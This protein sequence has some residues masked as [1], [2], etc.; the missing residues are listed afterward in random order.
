MKKK[1]YALEITAV[2][3]FLLSTP[4]VI[5]EIVPD[6]SLPN[7]STVDVNGSAIFIRGGT[8]RGSN[9][10][11]SFE[12]FSIPIGGTAVFDNAR[13]IVNIF[14]RISGNTPSVIEGILR[15][16]GTAN[17]FLINPSGIVFG[18]GATV[19]IGGSLF[20]TTAAFL[21]FE[22][23]FRYESGPGAAYTPSLTVN[24]PI[25]L[26]FNAT[27]RAIEVR[28]PGHD[29]SVSDP[30]FSPILPIPKSPARIRVESGR[31]LAL[32]GGKVTLDGAVLS[33]GTVNIGGIRNG[34]VLFSA[35]NHGF[36]FDYSQ[37]LEFGAINLSNRSAIWLGGRFAPNAG[38]GGGGRIELRGNDIAIGEGSILL[39][40]N[41]SRELPASDIIV[42]GR[43]VS[44]L[45][46]DT[47]G[48]F[49]S[50]LVNE[51]IAGNGGDI[52]VSAEN[53]ILEDGGTITT[54]TYG[55]GAGGDIEISAANIEINGF[56]SLVP[57]VFSSV[58]AI[59]YGN[60]RSGNVNANAES[61]GLFNA[62]LMGTVTFGSGD[63]GG[64]TI[65]AKDVII[66]GAS[67][68]TPN[69]SALTAATAGNGN[70]GNLSIETTTLTI[71]GGATIT[72][73]TAADGNAGNI[74]I[75]ASSIEVR[76]QDPTF[77]N[78]SRIFSNSFVELSGARELFQL[79]DRAVGNAGNMDIETEKLSVSET[80]FIGVG[81]TT[82]GRAGNLRVRANEL[83]ISDFGAI[84]AGSTERGQ[85]GDIS[86]EG[87]DLR[88]QGN[89]RLGS[90]A[91]GN[92]G[93]NGGNISIRFDSIILDD[94]AI[95]VFSQS[96][97]DGGNITIDA[98]TIILFGNSRITA[99]AIRGAGGNI[100]IDARAFLASPLSSI[101]ASS[102]LGL[103]GAVRISSP[104]TNPFSSVYPVTAQILEIDRASIYPCTTGENSLSVNSSRIVPPNPIE[105]P[106]SF[107][108]SEN[109]E[110][111]NPES[112]G[113]ALGVPNAIARTADGRSLLVRLCRRVN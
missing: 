98:G 1:K 21:Q 28:G 50:S 101:S 69:Y 84:G 71:T 59:S 90:P 6:L 20:A 5:A 36:T 30:I 37:A 19:N 52:T 18:S 110:I 8:E 51:A 94:S 70:G 25:G 45:G 22:D 26:G 35:S 106:G 3:A 64:L 53:L 99:D 7:P 57:T 86:L 47:G 63:A 48:S 44:L 102:Q 15:A 113:S 112:P 85:G 12:K 46:T 43:N 56:S 89:A 27:S 4:A 40:Q 74:R 108:D 62:G 67:T 107:I 54:K 111:A 16:N 105:A 68:R 17:L 97:G 31:T 109:Y 38:I 32:L 24:R 29:F 78:P 39:I 83:T 58:A 9:L 14:S 34:L 33:G 92:V 42:R 73:S 100:T 61:I 96:V 104:E 88:L 23:G 93:G 2:S 81:T 66:D 79:S 76:G 10:F 60:G 80:A 75:R 95:R 103:N 13:N 11:H 55:S 87:R 72:A 91:M 82:A 77:N 65:L 41:L 49:R